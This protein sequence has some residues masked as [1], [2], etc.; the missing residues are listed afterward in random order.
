M[1]SEKDKNVI[2]RIAKKYNVS[3]IILFGSGISS[4]ESSDIDIA[5]EG[6]PHKKFFK[7]YSEILFGISKSVDVVDISE[8]SLF[9]KLIT[10]EGIPIYANSE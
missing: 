10:S 1:I 3:K 9:T 6:L 7:F 5:V 8:K 4:K 2:I